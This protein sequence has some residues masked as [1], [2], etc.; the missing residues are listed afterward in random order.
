MEILTTELSDETV[1][2]FIYYEHFLKVYFCLII[3]KKTAFALAGNA[4]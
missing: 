2:S 4:N 3:L 1:Q